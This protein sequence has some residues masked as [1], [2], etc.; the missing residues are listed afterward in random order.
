M[1]YDRTKKFKCQVFFG[2]FFKKLAPL[3]HGAFIK[4]VTVINKSKNRYLYCLEFH[5]S[6]S[7]LR[8]SIS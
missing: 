6:I 7:C 5:F 4:L 8:I 3:R 2:N 1:I